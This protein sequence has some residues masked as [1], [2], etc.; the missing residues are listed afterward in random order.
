MI[1]RGIGH[2]AR[3]FAQHVVGIAIAALLRRA[4]RAPAPRSMVRPMHELAAED[5]HRL[6]D[7][8]ADDRLA[9]ARDQ[10]RRRRRR[11]PAPRASSRRTSRPV[12]IRPQVEALTNS[13]SLCPR[14][15][16]QSAAA[17][18]SR[19]SGRRSRR[20]ECAAAP[21][22][23]TSA[24]RLPRV[25]SVVFVQKRI[26]AAVHAAAGAHGFDELARACLDPARLGPA[27]AATWG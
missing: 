6:R 15:R 22:P 4:R 27:L 26:D 12:S 14:W 7:R 5:A 13:D 20:R 16:S 9:G 3:R 11:R 24:R 17:I 2:G 19:I 18:L 23:G 10:A 8:L 25:D 1:A 21:R